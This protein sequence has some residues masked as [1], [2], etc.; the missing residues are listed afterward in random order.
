MSDFLKR[1]F[2]DAKLALAYYDLGH[3]VKQCPYCA[4][5]RLSRVDVRANNHVA[6][7]LIETRVSGSEIL[8]SVSTERTS[9]EAW[10]GKPAQR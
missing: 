4:G 9:N 1:M 10:I 3:F 2:C 7:R 5:H 8:R 6:F